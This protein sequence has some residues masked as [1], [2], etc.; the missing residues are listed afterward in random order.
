M[1]AVYRAV[2]EC[3][4]KP[5]GDP[6][7]IVILLAPSHTGLPRI[8]CQLLRRR[9]AVLIHGGQMEQQRIRFLKRL[10]H[11]TRAVPLLLAESGTFRRWI[12]RRSLEAAQIRRR[13]HFLAEL[14]LPSSINN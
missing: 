8:Y 4:A 1:A 12:R 9:G 14:E 5:L 6:Q 2:Q 10:A 7:R 11:R 3:R 13:T